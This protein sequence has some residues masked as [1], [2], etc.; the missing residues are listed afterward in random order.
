MKNLRHLVLIVLTA[1][2]AALS[3]TGCV[4]TDQDSAVPWARP[5]S[6]EGQQPAFGGP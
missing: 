2:A 4:S 6:W 1:A 3:F 5:Q